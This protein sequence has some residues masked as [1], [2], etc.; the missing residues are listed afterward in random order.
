MLAPFEAWLTLLGLKTLHLRT[1]VQWS[2]AARLVAALRQHPAVVRTYYPGLPDHPGHA[3]HRRQATGDGGLVGLDLGTLRVA[4][5]FTSR[6]RLVNIAEK[7]GATESLVTHPASM[8]HLD[9]APGAGTP[10]ESRMG[11]P[12][13][14]RDRGPRGP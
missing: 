3:V 12:A 14:C 7:L 6:L 13:E 8:T 4:R 2:T 10:T 11:S 9:L 5:A 1:R